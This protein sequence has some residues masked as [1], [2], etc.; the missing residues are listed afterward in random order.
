MN[1]LIFARL[2]QAH[3]RSGLSI[4]AFCRKRG[5]A[6]SSFHYWRRRFGASPATDGFIEVQLT[7]PPLP[8]QP[9]PTAPPGLG[10]QPLVLL[11]RG[12]HL[13]LPPGF[14]AS[15]LGQ[16]LDVLKEALPC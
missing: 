9:S 12:A 10:E 1:A 15:A 2:H 5:L 4:A 14:S 13:T 16:C 6:L 8:A 3:V 11:Y 7:D